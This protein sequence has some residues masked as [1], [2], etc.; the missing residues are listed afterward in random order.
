M[1]VSTVLTEVQTRCAAMT[2]IK[3]AAL[4]LP[5]SGLPADQGQYP[6]I[7]ITPMQM[8]YVRE[9]MG[10]AG[11]VSVEYDVLITLYL[12]LPSMAQVDVV[13][14]A[15]PY[16]DRVRAKFASDYTLGGL[17]WNSDIGNPVDNLSDYG[18]ATSPFPYPT[19]QWRLSVQ[20]ETAAN[21]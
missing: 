3:A 7:N 6:R 1:S 15:A 2:G 11:K 10:A 12:G 5:N 19:V 9:T 16:L 20:E 4:G 17:C 13:S 14:A 18:E 8:S 21:A